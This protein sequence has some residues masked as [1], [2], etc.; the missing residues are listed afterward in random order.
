MTLLSAELAVC[1]VTVGFLAA[2]VTVGLLTGSELVLA[3]GSGVMCLL[4]WLRVSS[5]LNGIL[6]R[7]ELAAAVVAVGLTRFAF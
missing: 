1:V 4:C 6:T 2:V 5:R 7:S 3:M